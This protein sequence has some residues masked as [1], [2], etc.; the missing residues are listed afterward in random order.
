MLCP[1]PLAAAHL[2]TSDK[3]KI[4]DEIVNEYGGEYYLI[5]NQAGR[6]L[7]FTININGR[8]SSYRWPFFWRGQHP[9]NDYNKNYGS[10]LKSGEYVKGPPEKL[11]P[12]V[13]NVAYLCDKLNVNFWESKA[14]KLCVQLF[15]DY[16]RQMIFTVLK[17]GKT[18]L[19]PH[20]ALSYIFSA[21][22][23]LD[24]KTIILNNLINFIIDEYE[25]NNDFI[26][27]F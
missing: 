19:Y 13:E 20:M 11:R 4:L 6:P 15:Y 26:T 3:F 22:G 25:K 12:V 16:A 1:K 24:I 8:M 27:K 7:C 5:N 18:W 2:T 9:T 14:H 23:N 17:F 21:C 10:H